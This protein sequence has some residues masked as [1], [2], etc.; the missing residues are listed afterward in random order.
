MKPLP[1]PIVILVPSRV[2]N[3]NSE[4]SQV[5]L[6]VSVVL[7]PVI[8]LVGRLLTALH[9]PSHLTLQARSSTVLPITMIL[10]ARGV[11]PNDSYPNGPILTLS[12]RPAHVGVRKPDPSPSVFP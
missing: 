6:L 10:F 12:V 1:T 3:L 4:D 9:F 11:T 2:L 7:T 5:P 8:L